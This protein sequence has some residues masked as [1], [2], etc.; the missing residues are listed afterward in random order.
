MSNSIQSSYVQIL[1]RLEH[2]S[3]DKIL[4]RYRFLVRTKKETNTYLLK[5]KAPLVFYIQF[6]IGSQIEVCN[7]F[8]QRP[9]T[10]CF[11]SEV[12]DLLSEY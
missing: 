11:F 9:A 6:K 2:G 4:K 10:K 1:G 8:F 3:Q 5:T 7:N 12:S